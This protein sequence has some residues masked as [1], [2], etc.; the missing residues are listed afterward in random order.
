MANK[1]ISE[2]TVV[3]SLTATNFFPL[4]ETS[5]DP[6][7]NLIISKPN[8]A[9][10]IGSIG[11]GGTL[12]FIPKFTPDGVTLGNSLISDNGTSI[13]Y[14]TNQAAFYTNRSLVDKQ[15][16]DSQI[17]LNNDLAEILN[18][19]RDADAVGTIKDFTSVLSID[20][21]NRQLNKEWDVIDGLSTFTV[22]ASGLA[23]YDAT[24]SFTF[25]IP[26]NKVL[27]SMFLIIVFGLRSCI[28][29]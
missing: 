20:I 19:G 9:L 14:Q 5:G 28:I 4:I 13:V 17:G 11:G 2:F 7:L 18:N 29:V 26:A 24:T 3:T 1:K 22:G 16:V 6:K 27:P 15:Y 25:S 12:G 8:L 21:N 23:W 10:A